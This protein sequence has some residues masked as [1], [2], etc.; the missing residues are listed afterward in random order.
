MH[1]FVIVHRH[2][3]SGKQSSDGSRQRKYAGAYQG[4]GRRGCEEHVSGRG[5]G[6]AKVSVE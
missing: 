5:G 3:G 4:E 6:G 1:L 2:G